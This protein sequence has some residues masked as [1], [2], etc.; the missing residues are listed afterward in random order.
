MI[1]RRTNPVR[2][3]RRQRIGPP[4]DAIAPNE[5]ADTIYGVGDHKTAVFGTKT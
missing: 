3:T 2:E 1:K 5:K 4:G